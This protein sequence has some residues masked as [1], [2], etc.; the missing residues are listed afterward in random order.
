MQYIKKL[1]IVLFCLLHISSYAATS[2]LDSLLT[3]EELQ[4]LNQH[5]TSIV[6]APNP[7]W[8]PCDFID[9]KG[10]HRG[11]V[12]DYIQIFESKL[13]ITFQRK[14]LES[15]NDIIEGLKTRSVDVVGGIHPTEERKTYLKFTDVFLSTPLVLIIRK[16]YSGVLNNQAINNMKLACT[17][18]YSSS[19]F[20]HK[21]YPSAQI[22][23]CKDDLEALY[24]TSVGLSDGAVVD[25]MVASHLVESYGLSN[26]GNALELD[27]EWNLTFGIRSDYPELSSIL[28]K[29]L[30]TISTDERRQIFDSWIRVPSYKP[31]SI[32]EK[33]IRLIVIILAVVVFLLIIVLTISILLRR[34]VHSRTLDLQ[35]SKKKIE[36]S[37]HNYRELS[38]S[39]EQKVVERTNQ[40]L[41][42]NSELKREIAE[43]IQAEESDRLKTAFIQNLSHEI[44]TPMNGILGFAQLLKD[45][46]IHP[47]TFSEYVDSIIH[48]GERMMAT[49]NDLIEISKIES[50][51]LEI[52]KQHI[53]ISELLRELKSLYAYEAHQNKL[54]FL[55][56]DSS[57]DNE[58]IYTDRTVLIIIFSNLIKN[59]IKFTR[60]GKVTIGYRK[61]AGEHLFFVRDTGIGIE[62][63]KQIFIFDRF[64]QGDPSLSRGYEG[65]G[66]GLSI[67]KSYCEAL[68]GNICVQSSPGEGSEF[69]FTLPL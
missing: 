53:F 20:I 22:I 51:E 47:E 13:G 19:D 29:V 46:V 9:E 39:L 27:F 55:I 64:Q 16:E 8:P 62:A 43:R 68:G 42:L 10:V 67:A 23:E 11:I 6:Y 44:R 15:W 57:D 30:S 37:E 60:K 38:S 18:G 48:S 34:M 2:S 24:K 61:S 4:W 66:L 26:L 52:N 50:G 69:R 41:E 33:N 25:L 3:K 5:R 17:T 7:A 1:L 56:E 59:A 63:E 21:T 28:N 54:N 14:Y 45:R 12:A 58:S 36:E 40:L 32:L 49:I 65:S 35:E 31:K